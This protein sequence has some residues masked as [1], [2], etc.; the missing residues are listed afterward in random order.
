MKA[1]IRRSFGRRGASLLPIL[2]AAIVFALPMTVSLASEPGE[3]I[4]EIEQEV[5]DL[6]NEERAKRSL[7]PLIVNY[8]LQEAAWSHNE[9][10]V[11]TDC[12]SHHQCGNGRPDDRVAKTGYKA[13]T[14]GENIAQGYPNPRAAMEGWMSS[15]GHRANI[16]S[17]KYT[18]IGVAYNPNGPTWT[19]VFAKPQPDYA[20]VTPPAGAGPAPTPGPPCELP[21]DLNGDDRVNGQD[22][23]AVQGRFLMTE[24]HADWMPEYDLIQDGVINLYDI[25]EVVTAFGRTCP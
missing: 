7:P 2:A 11:A 6:V 15:S 19:Q 18:D 20:T 23:E 24:Q 9:H 17:S 13:I 14:V 4:L 21:Q 12:F 10:M 5:V 22:L 16:L 25:F 8:S 3:P 1:L